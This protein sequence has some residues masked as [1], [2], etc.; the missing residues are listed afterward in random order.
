MNIYNGTSHNYCS[1]E[2]RCLPTQPQ[3][4]AGKR[5][6]DQGTRGT[7]CC[8]L[9]IYLP[10]RCPWETA[11]VI[12]RRREQSIPIP[13]LGVAFPAASHIACSRVQFTITYINSAQFLSFLITPPF[14]QSRSLPS[15]HRFP[16]SC[17]LSPHLT[18]FTP[19]FQ[20]PHYNSMGKH[21][22]PQKFF[23]SFSIPCSPH[24]VELKNSSQPR[25]SWQ[26]SRSQEHPN[27]LAAEPSCHQA[28]ATKEISWGKKM[29]SRSTWAPLPDRNRKRG[30][31]KKQKQQTGSSSSASLW[32]RGQ[33]SKDHE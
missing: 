29:I 13:P 27:P 11:S 7:G 31:M 10:T 2:E 14:S 4:R 12:P 25:S 24:S 32:F 17:W 3:R 1:S 6:T 28:F 5:G 20:H 23:L 33:R 16:V 30:K 8:S 9:H 15:K 18:T 21:R 19:S 22:G 26:E